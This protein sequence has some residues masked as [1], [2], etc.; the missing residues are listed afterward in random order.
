MHSLGREPQDTD[1]K[2]ER[3]PRSGDRSFAVMP[4]A[5]AETQIRSTRFARSGQVCRPLRGLSF[6]CP[7]H[8][9]AHA[10]GYE[11]VA[12]PALLFISFIRFGAG[13]S[14]DVDLSQDATRE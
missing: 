10:P 11:Y 3:K 12:P 13:P 2:K 7:V 1:E 8:P 6:F 5:H 9:G 14:S 4:D